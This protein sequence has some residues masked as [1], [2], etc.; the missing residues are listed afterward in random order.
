MGSFALDFEKGKALSVVFEGYDSRHG[1]KELKHGKEQVI[2]VLTCESCSYLLLCVDQSM[3][4]KLK[5][6]KGLKIVWQVK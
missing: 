3:Q 5:M 4:K 1:R 6:E 2:L